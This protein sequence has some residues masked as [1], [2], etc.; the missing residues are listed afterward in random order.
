MDGLA[1]GVAAI[2]ALAF[3]V[4]ASDHGD[5]LVGS[6]AL[7]VAGASLGFLRHNFPPARIFLGDAGSLM[8]G[9][10]L[11]AIG[12]KLDLVGED[13]LIRSAVPL[14]ILGVPIFDMVLVILD[15]L[16]GKRPVYRGGIDH[17]SHRLADLGLS[18][19]A[20][21]LSTYGVQAACC[22]VALWLLTVS[23]GTAL[24]I[25]F[26]VGA[27][28]VTALALLLFTLAERGRPQPGSERP[29]FSR[30]SRE[31]L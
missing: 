13:G 24:S 6:F 4:V 23:D 5:Y 16:R 25:L 29:G 26:A 21:A 28:G 17:S 10:L 7:A 27:I 12:L 9:F 30:A 2:A 22:G 31:R 20:V 3:F 19:R 18:G 15:R 8:L 14:L 1:P 11:A